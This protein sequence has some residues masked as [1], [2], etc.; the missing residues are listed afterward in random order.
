MIIACIVISS[1]AL[2]AAGANLILFFVEKKRNA[3]RRRAM[4][5]YV[6]NQCEGAIEENEVY[7]KEFVDAFYQKKAK[8]QAE[9]DVIVSSKFSEL[10]AEVEKLKSGVVPNY[11]TALAAANAVNDFNT[12][13]SAIMNFDPIEAARSRRL[14]GDK[15]VS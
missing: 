3:A 5:D 15:E 4:L 6:N 1:L 2:L 13:I 14:G 10:F 9:Y 12:G 11:E 7:V 8:E